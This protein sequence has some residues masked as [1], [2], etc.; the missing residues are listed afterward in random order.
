M[1]KKKTIITI[2]ILA[3][4]MTGC[5]PKYQMTID[6]EKIREKVTFTLDSLKTNSQGDD[7]ETDIENTSYYAYKEQTEATLYQKKI[8]K[9]GDKNILTLTYDHDVE[10]FKNALALQYFKYPVYVNTKDYI[11]I[12]LQGGLLKGMENRL[13]SEGAE[14]SITTDNRVLQNNADRVDGNTYIWK[15]T[16]YNAQTKEILFQ[17]SKITK[18]V[19]TPSKGNSIILLVLVVGIAGGTTFLLW[20]FGQKFIQRRL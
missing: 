10:N 17:A 11:F 16:K 15:I 19:S 2:L 14:V 5:T 8:V 18:Q 4:F 20:Y 6:G 12:K 7:H 3:L 9:S 13:T 1:K